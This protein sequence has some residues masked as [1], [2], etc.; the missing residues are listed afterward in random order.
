MCF[1]QSEP[2]SFSTG[3]L[4]GKGFSSFRKLTHRAAP[5]V[6]YPQQGPNQAQPPVGGNS[7]VFVS[8][9]PPESAQGDRYSWKKLAVC[10]SPAPTQW[11]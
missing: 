5:A 3:R 2:W 7:N 11:T 6:P 1:T 10:L 8:Q 4:S 9:V